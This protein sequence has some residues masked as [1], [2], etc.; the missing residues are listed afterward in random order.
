MG[1][2]YN[3]RLHDTS[4]KIPGGGLVS[5]A[6]D[7]VRFAIAV[8]N[9]T[10]IKPETL[11]QMWTS[12]KTRDGK[13]LDYGLGWGLGTYHEYKLVSHSGGQAGVS[14]NL[15]L[16]PEKGLIIGVMANLEGIDVS[17]ITRRVG[18]V[19]LKPGR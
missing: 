19:L 2:V 10:F 8:Q 6:I 13:E 7:L 4:M 18:E 3:A 9:G 11:Q 15:A 16:L 1:A 12:A 17:R 5:T 14:T